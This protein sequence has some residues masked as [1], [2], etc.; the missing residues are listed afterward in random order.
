VAGRFAGVHT[1][2]SPG[3]E[4]TELA[5]ATVAAVSYAMGIRPDA[6]ADDIGLTEKVGQARTAWHRVSSMFY[7]TYLERPAG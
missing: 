7:G 4:L 6:R 5:N 1:D 2:S 3:K